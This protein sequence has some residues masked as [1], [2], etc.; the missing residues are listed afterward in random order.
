M[1]QAGKG[2]LLA[3]VLT[4]PLN[5]H[6]ERYR[7]DLILYLD[8]GA[9]TTEIAQTARAPDLSKALELD[10]PMLT[11]AGITLLPETDFSLN[12]QWQ[13]LRTSKRY[14]PLTRLAWLQSDP[15]SERSLPLHLRIGAPLIPGTHIVDG[16]VALRLSR[17]LFLD[18]DLAYT[19][20][21][22]EGIPVSYRL[23]EVRRMRRD[24]LHH[25]DSP[26]L[27]ILAQVAR[28]TETAAAPAASPVPGTA[29]PGPKEQLKGQQKKQEGVTYIR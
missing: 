4:L 11:P 23:K 25:L 16:T 24:E 5:A 29:P 2:L 15:P 12:E 10:G 7:V 20:P 27:G 3:L 22:S 21:N 8:K 6:A 9:S 1:I 17:Y 19:Q 28:V 14:Q 18:A 26:R 13:R